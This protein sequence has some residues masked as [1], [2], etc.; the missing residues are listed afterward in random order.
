V[1]TVVLVAPVSFH[2]ITFRQGRKPELVAFASVL[3]LI[4][5]TCFGVALVSAAF[6]I[7][8]FVLG[9]VAAIAFAI[10]VAGLE[11]ALWIVLP[12][13]NAMTRTRG[14]SAP[15]PTPDHPPPGR[16]DHQPLRDEI[17][18]QQRRVRAYHRPQRTLPSPNGYPPPAPGRHL[19]GCDHLLWY[20]PPEPFRN[21]LRADKPTH[22]PSEPG[23][24]SDGPGAGAADVNRD[25]A[26]ALPSPRRTRPTRESA[27]RRSA[28][29]VDGGGS[30]FGFD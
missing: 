1:A 19:T 13:P 30:R 24:P 21:T 9:L 4:G 22:T 3:A 28:L 2:R 10:L 29:I 16:G 25:V 7:A 23:R 26:S 14:T 12:S 8:D 5:L 27:T 15:D 18:G 11:A 20:R 6:L 17:P